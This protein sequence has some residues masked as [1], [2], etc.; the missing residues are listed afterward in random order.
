MQQELI[1]TNHVGEA[2]DRI[3]DREKPSQVFAIA[4]AN[5]ATM[6]MPQLHATSTSM[7]KA[8]T[9]T[10]PSGDMHKNIESLSY[11]WRQLGDNGCTRH[12]LIVNVGGGVVTDMG[13]FAAAT[14][15]RGVRFVNV[16]TTLLGAVD[17]AVGGKTGINFNG[18]KNEVGTFAQAI[19]VVISTT[20]F[21][22]LPQQEL[23]SGYAEMLKHGML[24]NTKSYNALLDYTIAE[25]DPDRLLALLEESIKVKASIVCQ[26]PAEQGMR[27]ALN[28]GHT[29]GHAFESYALSKQSPIPHGYAVARGL[30]VELVLSHLQLGFSSRELY[31]YANYV[32][33]N[34]GAYAISCD[35]YGE[36]L[37]LM[38]H[39]KKNADVTAINFT[40]LRD[41]GAPVIDILVD[42]EQVKTALDI[43][44]D[45]MHI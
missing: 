11:I 38:H 23:L 20:F 16:P 34:Y 33:E 6:V 22:T 15:N 14:F 32:L 9:V 40:L 12:S 17:A 45:L 1:F 13:A 31:K 41:I 44:R 39:D 19:S 3:V 5:T 10:V 25:S 8:Q 30:V 2:I 18:L 35:D 21:D 26:D 29:A 27:K 4:D 28:L 42:D 24:S 37:R 43:Y 36:L 7:R